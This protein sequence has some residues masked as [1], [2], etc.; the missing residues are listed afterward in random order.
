MPVAALVKFVTSTPEGPQKF[1]T[2]LSQ[3]AKQ[4]LAQICDSSLRWGAPAAIVIAKI[5]D[6]SHICARDEQPWWKA[7]G[8]D[9]VKVARKLWRDCPDLRRC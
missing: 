5:V 2:I 8:I 9:P 1:A 7:A 4:L 6:T 3:E